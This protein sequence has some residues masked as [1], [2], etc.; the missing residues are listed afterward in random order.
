MTLGVDP[1][2]EAMRIDLQLVEMF[3]F[4][5][6][7]AAVISLGLGRTTFRLL[8]FLTIGAFLTRWVLLPVGSD[9]LLPA[10]RLVWV[11]IALG[12]SWGILRIVLAP[13]R[14]DADRIFAALSLYILFG[15]AFGVL[16]AA[17][18]SI[19]PGSLAGLA[20]APAAAIS[21]VDQTIYFS[22][23]TLATLGYGDIVPV[24][25]VARGLANLE[26]LVGQLYLVVLVARLVSLYA[27]ERIVGA[28][29]TAAESPSTDEPFR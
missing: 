29:I 28:S 4:F 24:T 27:S 23:V 9:L 25:H 17:I 13:G 7:A 2:L 20:A 26:A 5:N 21:L 12:V 10:S 3:A 14:V 11:S 18:E 8:L 1:I 16:F 15:L 22:F 6:L 19:R